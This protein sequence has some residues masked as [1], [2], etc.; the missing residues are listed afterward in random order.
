MKRAVIYARVSTKR[1]ADDGLPLESQID[2]CRTKAAALGATVTKVF[3]D[4][5]ISGTTD[6]RPAFQDALNYCAVMPVDYFICWASSR[7]ARNHLDAGRYKALLGKYGARLVYSSTEVDLGTDDGWFIDA[8]GAVIDERYSR[9]V[10][11]DTRRSML[12]AARDGFFLGGTVPFGYVAIADGK[13][14]RLAAHPTEALIVRQ[15]FSLSL[16]GCG[17]KMIAMNLNAQGLTLRGKAWSK[18]S[19]TYILRNHIYAGWTVFN[20][21]TKRAK[22]PMEDWVRVANH[23]P[24]VDPE[25]FEKVQQMK[26]DRNPANVGGQPRSNFAF[27][28]LLRCGEC[29]ASLQ[30]CS[31]TG[32]G[33]T[34]H[35]YGCRTALSGKQACGFKR[36]RAE[37]FDEWMLSELLDQVL[38]PD[39]MAD[40]VQQAQARRGEWVQE[41]AGMRTALVAEVR[42]AEKSRANLYTVLE[43]HG[44]DAPN[45]G[46]LTVRLREWNARIK[47]LE[48]SLLELENEPVPAS[49]IPDIDPA[50]V[51]ETLRGIVMDC[52]DPRR[53]REFLGAFVKEITVNGDECLVDY[54]P[55][56]LV[57]IDN[58]ARVRGADK[59]LPNLGPLRIV[60]LSLVRPERREFLERVRRL[61]I[62]A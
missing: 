56:C 28:G 44:K 29:G 53:L 33:R 14:K 46:D 48:E 57:R 35:Y 41:R 18:N 30:T 3:V 16:Q 62:A 49:Q 24:L 61:A 58:R 36:V 59:W 11:S 51:A 26:T 15:I 45:L 17:A 37:L 55:E 13:R 38:T 20:R 9:Q 4:G 31:G 7:F 60:R 27:T 5:G 50:D 25:D 12:K 47:T 39:R 43:L 34:Y 40:I 10:A 6:R 52:T 19:L 23:T 32:R 21:T 1:Q 54:H 22:N 8:I 2:H 42:S